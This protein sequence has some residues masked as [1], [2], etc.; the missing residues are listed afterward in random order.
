[1]SENIEKRLAHYKKLTE[2]IKK[3]EGAL[4]QVKKM[5]SDTAKALLEENGK[6]QLY[7]LGDGEKMFISATKIGTYFLA[8][9]RRGRGKGKKNK[10]TIQNGKVVEQ[11]VEPKVETK[12]SEPVEEPKAEPNVIEA[13]ATLSASGTVQAGDDSA[14]TTP[15][16]TSDGMKTVSEPEEEPV[17]EPDP[18]DDFDP[19]DYMDDE[20]DSEP[21]SEPSEP[22]AAQSAPEEAPPAP[23]PPTAPEEEDP[24]AAALAELDQK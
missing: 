1:M 3:L 2:D 15:T 20:G 10:K 8:P 22:E 4:E 11:P 7:D 21:E 9:R 14:I 16:D 18:E 12:A 17:S 13:S 19:A 23:E 5:R 6:D 24:L